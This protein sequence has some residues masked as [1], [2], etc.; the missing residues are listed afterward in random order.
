MTKARFRELVK[1]LHPDLSGTERT[2]QAFRLMVE[3]MRRQRSRKKLPHCWCGVPVARHAKR[4]RLHYRTAAVGAIALSV[5]ALASVSATRDLPYPKKTPPGAES[6]RGKEQRLS[7][8]AMALP[9]PVAYAVTW[10]WPL[11]LPRPGVEFAVEW[12]PDLSAAMWQLIATTNQ[13]P[14]VMP[15]EGVYRVASKR[16]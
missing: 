14:V 2:V 10:T 16:P 8:A 13:P 5:A 15:R 6:P 3:N 4:C 9:A 11:P 7:V 12:K 1:K